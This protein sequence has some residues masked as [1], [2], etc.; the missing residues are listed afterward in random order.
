MPGTVFIS[1]ADPENFLRGGGGS[2][3]PRRGLTENFN[4][5]KINN[6]AIPGGGV[7][8]PCPPLWIR[9]C[10]Y[11]QRYKQAMIRKW[12]PTPKTEG[13]EKTIIDTQ[14]L[15]LRKHIVNRV[16]SYFSSRRPLCYTNLTKNLKRFKQHKNSTSKHKTIRTTT[17]VLP[18]N[19]Q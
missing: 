3:I 10:I 2:K 11:L 19:D 1:C 15:I 9:P 18:W 12:F 6:L 13:R 8:T 17:E 4:M 14:V 16:S 5:A 7:R